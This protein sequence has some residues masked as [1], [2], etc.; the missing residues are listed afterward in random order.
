[1]KAWLTILFGAWGADESNLKT[2]GVGK[3]CDDHEVSRGN[4]W[5][6]S[7]WHGVHISCSARFM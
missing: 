4:F 2:A 6:G 5:F 7:C 1:L 3:V